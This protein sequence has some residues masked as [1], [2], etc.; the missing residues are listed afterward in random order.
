[1]LYT[2]A[3]SDCNLDTRDVKRRCKSSQH[4]LVRN[5]EHMFPD[6]FG[7]CRGV[8]CE[9]RAMRYTPLWA[10]RLRE[11]LAANNWVEVHRFALAGKAGARKPKTWHEFLDGGLSGWWY[12]L[13][14]GSGIFYR[15]GATRVAP[16]IEV[17][18]VG[19]LEVLSAPLSV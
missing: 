4:E 19:A 8:V 13:A 2:H 17:L 5:D 16:T 15:T 18:G 3:A 9:L 11:G 6:L 10:T 12:Y 7:D 14:P 1:M